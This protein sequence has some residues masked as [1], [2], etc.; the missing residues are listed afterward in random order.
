MVGLIG[1]ILN[2][3]GKPPRREKQSGDEKT[4][5]R[6]RVLRAAAA[7]CGLAALVLVG[8]GA[9]S[10][11]FADYAD[12]VRTESALTLPDAA[13]VWRQE[14][15]QRDDFLSQVRLG[16]LYSTSQS[17]SP[18]ESKNGGYYDPVE[19]YV[20]YFMA[21]R[22]GHQ[23]SVA[24]DADAYAAIVNIRNS[25]ASNAQAVFNALTFEQRLD[26][27]ARL[28]YILSSRG[29]EGFLALGR[30][31]ASSFI[32]SGNYGPWRPRET[33]C[34][35]SWWA[36]DK[37]RRGLWSAWAWIFSLESP[38]PPKTVRISTSGDYSEV[39]FRG[40]CNANDYVPPDDGDSQSGSIQV[41][42]QSSGQSMAGPDMSSQ[43]MSGQNG[44]MVALNSGGQ[45]QSAMP[46][47]GIAGAAQDA[48]QNAGSGMPLINGGGG[49]GDSMSQGSYSGGFGYGSGGFGMGGGFFGSSIS[50]VFVTN[51]AE[52]LTYFSIAQRLGHP[53]AAPYVANERNVI[54]YNSSDAARIIADAE[55]RARFWT[56]AYE[57]YPGITAKG[58][59][60][61]D[62]AIPALEDRMALRRFREIPDSA[63]VEALEFRGYLNRVRPCMGPRCGRLPIGGAVAAFQTAMDWEPTGI[64]TPLQA[65]RLIQM[66]AVDGDAIAQDRLG[67]MYAKGIGVE[68]NF[69]RAEKWFIKSANQRFPDAL[70]NLSVLYRVGPSGIEPDEPKAASF[71]AQAMQAGYRQANCELAELLRQADAA[72]HDRPVGTRR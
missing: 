70:Y 2:G 61:S 68:R 1:V 64:L 58:K 14:A 63:V 6:R 57:Y 67:I 34:M 24:D 30:I 27:R 71:A 26:A 54:R 38:K 41:S 72:G 47:T 60:H 62:E 43:S 19:S 17:I 11:V 46:S 5:G 23:Y 39:L 3:R 36:R 31:H 15:W 20:W 45:D 13:K 29:A 65:V 7:V 53:L 28:L 50:S 69:L 37:L 52:A 21:L 22:P 42:G 12:G 10:A 66:A 40:R 32:N 44:G 25:A 8:L 33:V 18:N 48:G 56:P 55:R 51:D 35:R 4:T 49:G 59:L 9:G 16:D